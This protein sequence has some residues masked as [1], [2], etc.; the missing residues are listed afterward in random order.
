M[1][2]S[3]LLKTEDQIIK[4]WQ[5]DVQDPKVSICCITYNHEAYIED[6]L[7]GFL[8]QETDF[9]FE[10]LI[11]DDASTDRTSAIIREYEVR[12]PR[13][14]KP[15]YQSSNQYSRGVKP[16]LT[17]NFPR[18]KGN[19]IALCE[20]DDFWV[21]KNKLQNQY[22]AMCGINSL[23]S[24]HSADTM[25]FDY[26]STDTHRYLK[27]NYSLRDTF[28]RG[29]HFIQTCTIMFSRGCLENFD[30]SI[31]KEAPVGDVLLR[32]W[33]G[34]ENGIDFV[35]D[36]KAI[37]RVQSSSS[38]SNIILN[39]EYKKLIFFS[40]LLYVIDKLLSSGKVR[41]LSD[42]RFFRSKLTM[43]VLSSFSF[44]AKNKEFT[45]LF[46][47]LTG[48]DLDTRKDRLRWVIIGLLGKIIRKVASYQKTN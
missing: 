48:Y 19:F 5:G 43:E 27:K 32:I 1:K 28:E 42:L 29:H 46:K 4:N 24:F 34:D 3:Q 16:N 44:G 37:Y 2:H 13:L 31:F 8:N 26:I 45:G 30:E 47:A 15:I 25:S 36:L 11:H 23:I 38:W 14:I 40:Q 6:A 20:G 39:D 12:Y 35:P 18:A 21:S 7:A 41:S 9:P 22:T 10:I 33:C 17:Y